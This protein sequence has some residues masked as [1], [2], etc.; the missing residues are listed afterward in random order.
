M[1]EKNVK[2]KGSPGNRT[3]YLSQLSDYS[4]LTLSENHTTRPAILVVDS[5][6]LS[7]H[8]LIQSSSSNS[9]EEEG[10]LLSLSK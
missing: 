6:F 3:R 5:Q 7:V 10:C 1:K 4:G 8:N 2:N 9:S